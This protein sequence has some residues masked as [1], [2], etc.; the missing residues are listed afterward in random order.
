MWLWWKSC[1][2]LSPQLGDK[3]FVFDRQHGKT[4][5][6]SNKF[7]KVVKSRL[8]N[9][10]LFF[11]RFWLGLQRPM[12]FD[13]LIYTFLCVCTDASFFCLQNGFDKY[14]NGNDLSLFRNRFWCPF[15]WGLSRTTNILLLWSIWSL[16]I[17]TYSIMWMF[18]LVWIVD[19]QLLESGLAFE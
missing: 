9:L 4:L 12:V 2:L 6:I 14:W 17:L 18:H 7:T 3:Q 13:V 10:S 8:V 1:T 11:M 15:S 5:T 19:L 16:F